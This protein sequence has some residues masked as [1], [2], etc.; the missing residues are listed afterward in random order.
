MSKGTALGRYEQLTSERSGFLDRAEACAQ[1]TIPTLF[2]PEGTSSNHE[3]KTPRQSLGAR[4]VNHL[5]NKFLVTLFPPNASFFRLTVSEADLIKHF[6]QVPDEGK[7]EEGLARVERITSGEIET[8]GFRSPLAETFKLLLVTG[9]ALLYVP[10]KGNS[11]RVFRLNTYCVKRD[12]E[13]NVLEIV[14]KES[15]APSELP[16]DARKYLAEQQQDLSNDKSIDIYTRVVKE[17]NIWVSVQE[18]KGFT[19]PGS[20]KTYPLDKS[21]WV[22]LRYISID[23]ESYGRSMVEEYFGDLKTLND[24]QRAVSDGSLAAAKVLFFVK[25]NGM[26]KKRHVQEAN[27]FDI[28]DGNSEDVDTLQLNKYADFRVALEMIRDLKE[29]LGQAFL[30]HSSVQRNAERVTAEEIRFMA[31]ELE[32]A[33]GGTYSVL[34]Q[35]LQLPLVNIL[36]SELQRAG[37]LPALPKGLVKPQIITGMEALG[38]GQ[39]LNRLMAMVKALEPL[40]PEVLQRE[41]NLGDFITR[42]AASL[43]VEPAGLVKTPEDKAQEQQQ[44]QA[45]MQQQAAMDIGGKVAPQVVKGMM[46]N[47]EQTKEA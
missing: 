44:Q 39:D 22:P 35:E 31:Q 21:P 6:G 18:V 28:I 30:L 26:T 33:L 29:Q 38:R 16:Q 15:M 9:N 36:M 17:D 10:R 11:L 42:V 23:G 5:A 7:V 40:G 3:F 32:S 14:V 45:M 2:P 1:L 37:K 41:L 27:N 43:G 20:R 8:R 47:A 19:L 34:A 46:D 4:G 24:L 13:G 25:P 12:P